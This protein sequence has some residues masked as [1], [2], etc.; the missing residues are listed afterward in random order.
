MVSKLEYI[1]NQPLE[2]KDGIVLA[3]L[4]M[5]VVMSVGKRYA[6]IEFPKLALLRRSALLPLSTGDI[7]FCSYT[8]EDMVRDAR[9]RQG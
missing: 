7:R 4:E 2:R 3:N 9:N 8:T 1:R 6:D 5:T